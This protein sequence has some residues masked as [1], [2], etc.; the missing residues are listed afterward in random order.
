MTE[1]LGCYCTLS[2]SFIINFILFFLLQLSEN[3]IDRMKE[4]SPSG[5]KAQ[6]YSGIYGASGIVTL[7]FEV[8]KKL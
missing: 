2:C 3:V 6:R 1:L 4:S 5:S 7:Y 8:F